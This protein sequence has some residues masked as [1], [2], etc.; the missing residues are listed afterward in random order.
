MKMTAILHLEIKLQYQ[1]ET[2]WRWENSNMM[3]ISED[4]NHLRIFTFVAFLLS[5]I[6]AEAP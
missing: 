1:S 5:M 2:S 6:N 4:M 3:A